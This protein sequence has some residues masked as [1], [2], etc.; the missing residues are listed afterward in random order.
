MILRPKEKLIRSADS[1]GADRIEVV[2]RTAN[3]ERIVANTDT[4]VYI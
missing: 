3:S 2:E 4:P 1:R